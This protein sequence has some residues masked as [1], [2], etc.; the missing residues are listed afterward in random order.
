MRVIMPF[1]LDGKHYEPGDALG[2]DALCVVRDLIWRGLAVAVPMN[3]VDGA[4]WDMES[5]L[6]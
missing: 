6:H 2:I 5:A 4:A 1:S 3:V